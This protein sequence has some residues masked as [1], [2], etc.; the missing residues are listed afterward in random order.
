M[1]PIRGN[2]FRQH[3]FKHSI[4]HFRK[5]KVII[6]QKYEEV[7]KAFF[8]NKP[9]RYVVNN[10]ADTQFLHV[11][12]KMDYKTCDTDRHKNLENSSSK[13]CTQFH[14][15]VAKVIKE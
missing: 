12:I 6:S 4:R 14:M 1:Q 5:K 8:S 13:K 15:L 2:S 7:K 11:K 9:K 10:H 3:F